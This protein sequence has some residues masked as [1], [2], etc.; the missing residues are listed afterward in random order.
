MLDTSG[1]PRRELFR[2]DRLHLNSDG[3]ALWKGI[4]APYV[5]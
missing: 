3:Y 5:Y 2:A 1:K 4:I